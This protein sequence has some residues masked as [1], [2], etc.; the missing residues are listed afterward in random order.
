MLWMHINNSDSV[1]VPD[2]KYPNSKD[3]I[4]TTKQVKNLKKRLREKFKR[5]SFDAGQSIMTIRGVEDQK[6][7]KEWV[8][9]N[10]RLNW[11]RN[12]HILNGRH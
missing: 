2:L 6:K 4:L 11:L 1:L 12:L 9:P 5:T 7:K 8:S 3:E 10:D